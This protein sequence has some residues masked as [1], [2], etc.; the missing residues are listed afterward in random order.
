MVRWRM[1]VLALCC[2]AGAAGPVRAETDAQATQRLHALFDAEWEWEMRDDPERATYTGDH[3]YGAQLTDRSRAADEK[4]YAHAR[5][6]LATLRGID[7][8]QL[9][10]AD[11]VSRDIMVQG[12][13]EWLDGEKFAGLNTL[14]LDGEGGLHN[15]LASLLRVSP[16]AT[17]ADV[18]NMLA[19]L[20]QFP[21][22]VDQVIARLRDGIA[23][24]WVAARA[25]MQQVPAQ[26]DGQL[27]DD[28]TRS[29]LY[30]PF[31]RLGMG[32]PPDTRTALAA[33]GAAALRAHVYPAMRRLRTFI[34][35]EYLPHTRENG[36]MSTRPSG[37]AAYDYLV[38]QH[39]T[40]DLGAA[41]V[42]EIGLREVARLRGE[43]EAQMRAAGFA[44]SFAEF[45]HFLN[46]DPR[47]FYTD[48]E[49]LLAG[50]RDIAKRVDPELPKLFAELPRTPY[51]VRAIPAHEGIGKSE[52]YS[53]P[54]RDGSGAG[55]FNA[56]VVAIAQRPIWNMETL[57]AHE[58]VPGHHLQTARAREL[59]DLPRFRR[60]GG[61]TAY[62]EGWALY[63]ETLGPE[64]GLYKTPY[65]RFG[66]L[67][68]QSLRAARLVVDTGIHAFGWQRTQAIEWMT[69]RTGMAR[70]FIEPQVDRYYVWP[71]QALSYMIGQLKI[72][73]L[74]DRAR[75]AL[76]ARFDIRRFHM[77]V[78]DNGAM[79]LGALEQ[80]IDDWIAREKARP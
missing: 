36:A 37:A 58:A 50:Y 29:P 57:F 35:D 19:R 42:H 25:S 43:M 21:S 66:H 31:T 79:P 20:A 27:P 10:P 72:I 18:R 73:E 51:G 23:M 54:P 77:A 52:N 22:R 45:V 64:L 78:L 41:Q 32:I 74:R 6:R 9:A 24:G 60:G 16:V 56:N 17:E 5:E 63:A 12:T 15:D 38:R 69:E 2:I 48:P 76:G 39:T 14:V 40:T 46:T 71:G 80:Q 7:R 44:G 33:D 61:Y 70:E 68:W 8:E 53:G 3:R 59:T 75:A 28:V 26:I 62:G 11:R 13:Q 55:W 49:A 4:R 34:V 65:T 67:Q 30:E 47:F 1:L